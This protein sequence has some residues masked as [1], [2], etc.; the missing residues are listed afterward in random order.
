MQLSEA[1]TTH[2]F[3][4]GSF[5]RQKTKG[6]YKNVGTALHSYIRKSPKDGITILKFIYG[7]L[8]NVKLIYRYKLAP[9]DAC[10][11]C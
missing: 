10:P 11:L 7:Q 3:T 5:S 1:F 9:T 8:Y 6:P 2:P 4:Y